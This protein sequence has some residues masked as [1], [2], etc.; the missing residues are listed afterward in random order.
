MWLGSLRMQSVTEVRSGPPHSVLG[1]LS[2]VHMDFAL[3]VAVDF[4]PLLNVR[5]FQRSTKRIRTVLTL[6]TLLLGQL[7]SEFGTEAGRET[8]RVPG[9]AGKGLRAPAV[10]LRCRTHRCVSR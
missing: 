4:R 6:S 7:F 9:D 5:L 2:V 1:E 8:G 10:L 3:W